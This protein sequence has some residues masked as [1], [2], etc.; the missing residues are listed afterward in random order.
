MAGDWDAAINDV[1]MTPYRRSL[2]DTGLNQARW[3]RPTTQGPFGSS[4]VDASGNI[5][6]QFTGGFGQLNDAL[7]T[8]AANVAASPMD[9]GQFGS[10]GTGEAA[11]Q[12]ASQ[13]AYGQSLSRLNPFWEKSGNKLRTNL[14]QSGMG[15]SDA[16]DS[17]MG[18][19][20]RARNDAYTGA[21]SDAMGAGM[22]AQQSAFNGN[23]ASRQNNL[24][25][26]LR[27]QT[28][29]FEELAGM[30]GFLG[31]QPQVGRDNSMLMRDAGFN[32]MAPI[33]AQAT[34]EQEALDEYA[35]TGVFKD[36]YSPLDKAGAGDQ[37]RKEW[38]AMD[39]R[40]RDAYRALTSG[41]I[42]QLGSKG[43]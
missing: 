7:T 6:Q 10:I 25:N 29:P 33:T 22:T 11:G 42:G 20:G 23:L 38:E 4:A 26:A 15:D 37:R 43:Y 28:Q 19:F 30:K 24:A 21:M 34:H 9:W 14:F 17:T 18:E 31:L 2:A 12:Q 1:D 8:Q 41:G 16:G 32:Q 5:N 36:G 27:G 35:R 40:Q 3:N 39:P 13:A